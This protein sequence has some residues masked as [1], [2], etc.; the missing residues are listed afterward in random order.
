MQRPNTLWFCTWAGGW[1]RA[2]TDELGDYW[3]Q[4]LPD[5]ACNGA[6]QNPS[7]YI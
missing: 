2:G 1:I 6:N 3:Y 4:I 7:K 5:L